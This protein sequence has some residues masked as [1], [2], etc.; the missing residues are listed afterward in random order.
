MLEWVLF[1]IA[2]FESLQ[3]VVLA[4]CTV[5]IVRLH[6]DL[7]KNTRRLD[8][9][10]ELMAQYIEDV[11]DDGAADDEPLPRSACT[12]IQTEKLGDRTVHLWSDGAITND[13]SDAIVA[14]GVSVKG[15]HG[16]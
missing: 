7:N 14:W 4:M 3:W 13:G 10:A 2:V 11:A 5:Y 6:V 1:V 16:N 9:M 12:I 15:P 8:V